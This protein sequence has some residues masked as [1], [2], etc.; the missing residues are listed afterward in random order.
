MWFMIGGGKNNMENMNCDKWFYTCLALIG[1][2][3]AGLVMIFKYF[4]RID[5]NSVKLGQ[6]DKDHEHKHVQNAQRIQQLETKI[7][8]IEN[9]H[10]P[11][12]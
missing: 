4:L 5:R 8:E 10:D 6:A 7:Q 2:V 11:R 1:L 12:P 3:F 9:K